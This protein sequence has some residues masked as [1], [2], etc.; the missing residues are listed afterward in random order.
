[1]TWGKLYDPS[2]T[3]VLHYPLP[4]QICIIMK[5]KWVA[6]FTLAIWIADI[7]CSLH[8]A[9]NKAH[10]IVA[11]SGKNK[12]S[13]VSFATDPEGYP[14]ATWAETD[15]DNRKKF[16]FAVF[17]REQQQ[18]SAPHEIPIEPNTNLHEEGMPKI[19]LKQD[20][21][22]LAV[23]ETSAP[24]EKN[25][26][27]GFVRYIQSFD[28]GKSWTRP[29]FLHRD[30]SA[31]KGH[32]FASIARLADG[33]IGACWLD[34]SLGDKKNGRS[35]VFAKTINKEG[36][37]DETIIDSLAC[38]CCRTNIHCD[39]KGNISILFRDILSDSIRDISIITSSDNGNTFR[40]AVPFTN[41]GWVINGCPHNGPSVYNLNGKSYASWFTGGSR[42]GVHYAELNSEGNV[43][44]RKLISNNARNIQLT[45]LPPDTKLVVYNETV[46]IEDSFYTKINGTDR[47][48]MDLT[49]DKSNASFPVIHALGKEMVVVA[50]MDNEQVWYRLV[51][52]SEI[53]NAPLFNSKNLLKADKRTA[54]IKLSSN[55]D[56][57]CGM[58]VRIGVTDTTAYQGRIYGF[59]SKSCREKFIQLKK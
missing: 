3:N 36:F 59:C 56:P 21:T 5:I 23:Y 42:A 29:A 31:G 13:C 58:P 1:M 8:P 46:K 18:F 19:A 39:P 22:L 9:K 11:L 17:E 4:G 53:I 25:R 10:R 52:I 43:T 50:W 57:V 24:T 6:I 44:E 34:V 26:F 33:E 49:S 15:P 55:N 20:G 48:S 12:A 7:S 51:S 32:S 35:L 40:K 47:K 2:R 54:P 37:T 27:A 16:F 28:G 41:D 30:T 45:I 38:Q 14:I